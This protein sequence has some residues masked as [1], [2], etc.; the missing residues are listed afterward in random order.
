MQKKII[1]VH[2]FAIGRVT[3]NAGIYSFTLIAPN[4]REEVRVDHISLRPWT[5]P[6][7]TRSDQDGR[8]IPQAARGNQMDY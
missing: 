6:D 8:F 5:R 7:Q 2:L 3:S 1:P 4:V